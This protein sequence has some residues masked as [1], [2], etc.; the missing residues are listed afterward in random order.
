LK[1]IETD[2]SFKGKIIE[3][4]IK[5]IE[6]NKNEEE[7]NIIEKIYNNQC[8]NIY[9]I[10][11]ASCLIE[12]II[13]NIFN[14]YLKNIFEICGNDNIFTTLAEIQANNYKYIEK[15]KVEDIINIYLDEITLERKKKYKPK[16]LF[17]YNIP[18]FYNFY[19]NISNYINKNINLIYFNNENRYLVQLLKNVKS[20]NQVVIKDKSIF[21]EKTEFFMNKDIYSIVWN[22]PNLTKEECEKILKIK[23]LKYLI[24]DDKLINNNEPFLKNSSKIKIVPKNNYIDIINTSKF[25]E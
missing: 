23:A 1:Y 8:I 20:V 5:L 15:E 17:N 12:Y 22:L 3:I 4:T 11:I 10:D 21:E 13:E 19:I 2:Q 18:G 25:Y 9:S 14:E 7:E 16:F 24:V 6:Q